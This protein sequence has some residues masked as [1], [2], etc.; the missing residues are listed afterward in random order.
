[1]AWHGMIGVLQDN[2]MEPPSSSCSSSSSSSSTS[3]ASAASRAKKTQANH[4]VPWYQEE[5]TLQHDPQTW[6]E[7]CW[8]LTWWLGSSNDI[9]WHGFVLPEIFIIKMTWHDVT[10]H[11]VTWHDMTWCD[12]TWHDVTWNWHGMRCC[13]VRS[14]ASSVCS[15]LISK[16]WS[17]QQLELAGEQRN[18][19][20]QQTG[21]MKAA[22]YIPPLSPPNSHSRWPPLADPSG[23]CLHSLN[24]SRKVAEMLLQVNFRFM[25]IELTTVTSPAISS[26]GTTPEIRFPPAGCTGKKK[27]CQDHTWSLKPEAGVEN[28]SCPMLPSFVRVATLGQYSSTST[29]PLILNQVLTPPHKSEPEQ[30]ATPLLLTMNYSLSAITSAVDEHLPVPRG[31]QKSHFDG[32]QLNT[33]PTPGCS[34][35]RPSLRSSSRTAT[36]TPWSWHN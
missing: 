7:P 36:G 22:Y 31:M 35:R 33:T 27:D 25:T 8:D 21:S 26:Q 5:E 24:F 2:G 4:P 15:S 30:Q 6:I 18:V 34:W 13:E 10:W 19:L 23:E 12:M 29:E 11:D 3:T 28:A 20:K 17:Y 16:A 32:T 9:T 1:M 14:C